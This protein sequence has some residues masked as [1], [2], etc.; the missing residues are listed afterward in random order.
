MT[1]AANTLPCW[2]GD[3][4]M[5]TEDKSS[6]L[7]DSVRL[8]LPALERARLLARK[9]AITTNTALVVVRDG[10]LLTIPA[11]VLQQMTSEPHAQEAV[12]T[13]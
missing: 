3:S 1:A 8:A 13:R 12:A 7:P 10:Q 11:D 2:I 5:T 4:T 9:T 6:L